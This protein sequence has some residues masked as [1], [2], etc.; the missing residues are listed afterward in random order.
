MSTTMENNAVKCNICGGEE[1]DFG[2]NKRLS[3]TKKLPCCK[4]CGSAERHR[5]FRQVHQRLKECVPYD[6]YSCLQISNDLS[7]E[8][9]WFGKYELSIYGRQ[10]SVDLQ[11]IERET[12]SYD[13]VICNHVLEHVEN[14]IKAL[15]ELF[16]IFSKDGLLQLSVPQPM[17]INKTTD[18]GFPDSSKFGHY[19]MYGKD[20][21]DKFE[22]TMPEGMSYLK[23]IS[24]DPV[25][26][27]ADMCFIFLKSIG[28]AY[29]LKA[30]L[31]RYF[32]CEI[33][34]R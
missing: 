29:C 30:Y 10:N 13:L 23:V 1:F 5:V 34:H 14:D 2:P 22:L 20:I 11:D 17:V 33:V 15:K 32:E 8:S 12:E 26:E 18:W 7:V 4:S 25:T 16:R 24:K 21:K 3:R 6:L 27:A 9:E 19:R 28:F 31:S